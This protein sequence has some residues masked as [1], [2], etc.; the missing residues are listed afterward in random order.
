MYLTQGSL[1]QKKD[2]PSHPPFN[3]PT[4]VQIKEPNSTVKYDDILD[5]KSIRNVKRFLPPIMRNPEEIINRFQIKEATKN[6]KPRS[7]S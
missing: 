3:M 1:F 7:K 4:P 2:S 6:A 5:R